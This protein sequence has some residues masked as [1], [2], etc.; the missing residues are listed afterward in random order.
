M[1]NLTLNFAQRM[2]T[3]VEITV[4]KLFPAGFGWQSFSII[5]G[6]MGYKPTQAG[7]FLLTGIGDACGVGIGH[8]TYNIAKRQVNPK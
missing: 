8:F 5:A 1:P 2:A 7:F 4:S 6:N 3:T